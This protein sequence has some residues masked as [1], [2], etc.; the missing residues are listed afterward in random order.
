M[1]IFLIALTFRMSATTRITAGHRNGFRSTVSLTHLLSSARSAGLNGQAAM[2]NVYRILLSTTNPTRMAKRE[3]RALI[4]LQR[5]VSSALLRPV[6]SFGIRTKS[7]TTVRTAI[8]LLPV[9]AQMALVAEDGTIPPISKTLLPSP[10]AKSR[11]SE[12]KRRIDGPERRTP[13]RLASPAR[14]RGRNRRSAD[15]RLTIKVS[16]P[17]DLTRR[18]SSLRMLKVASTVILGVPHRRNR[19]MGEVMR[20]ISSSMS[21]ENLAAVPNGMYN[22]TGYLS[23]RI[24]FPTSPQYML[25]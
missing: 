16:I 11:K 13:T 9:F 3:R 7:H 20:T 25:Y 10:L 23:L 24:S 6:D 4:C 1:H 15:Q 18:R 19:P 2:T 17:D 8:D 22:I 5:A 12:R 21:S 14:R